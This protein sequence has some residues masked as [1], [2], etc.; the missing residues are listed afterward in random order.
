MTKEF[1]DIDY[2]LGLMVEHCRLPMSESVE[3]YLMD[4]RILQLG[5]YSLAGGAE[6]CFFVLKLHVSKDFL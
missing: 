1:F 2:V 4:P 3:G 5:S 6:I